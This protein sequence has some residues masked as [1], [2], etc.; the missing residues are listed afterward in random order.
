VFSRCLDNERRAVASLLSGS[1]NV[2]N[3]SGVAQASR[4]Q[5]AN[6]VFISLTTF[7]SKARVKISAVD[8]DQTV[9][10]TS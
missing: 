3:L 4:G 5:M 2:R 10:V 9:G 7:Y 6:Y 8:A 1:S